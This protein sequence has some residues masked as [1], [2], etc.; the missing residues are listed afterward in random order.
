MEKSI[1]AC[2]ASA[3]LFP[4]LLLAQGSA[5]VGL[6]IGVSNYMG[7][8]APSPIAANETQF[9]FGGQYRQML[10]PYFAVKGSVTYGKISG[11]DLNKP[12]F[13]AVKENSGR[14][15]E[16]GLLEFTLQ[17]E[18]HFL[19]T[20][21]YNNAGLYNRQV[22]P[23]IGLG[24][25][26]LF[27][28]AKVSAPEGSNRRYPEADDSSTFLV[29]PMTLGIRF[30]LTES[31][32]MAGEFGLRATFTDYL[33]GISQTGNPNTNDHYFFGGIS[34]LYLFEADYGGR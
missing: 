32:V 31:L 13:Q 27:A 16:S 6:F 19:G 2:I 25:G 15:M 3:L 22:S 9:A 26:L 1:L 8:L 18:W 34:V 24:A 5:E 10:S 30:D 33:D 28:N 29:F 4:A 11:S 7:D 12:T 20:P 23:F 17:G 21:R 14:Q